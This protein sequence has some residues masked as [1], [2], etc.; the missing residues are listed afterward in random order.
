M[1][2]SRGDP[3][4]FRLQNPPV[5]SCSLSAAGQVGLKR[6]KLPRKFLITSIDTFVKRH[7]HKALVR[8]H[9]IYVLSF[10]TLMH[11]LWFLLRAG[12]H[13]SSG[14]CSLGWQE[15]NKDSTGHTLVLR[16][17][18]KMERKRMRKDDH[19]TGNF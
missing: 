15:N 6:S 10:A 5:G 11:T 12:M 1:A 17:D 8:N 9:C 19:S 16:K 3:S 14:A 18:E 2:R 13:R 4:S 7:I